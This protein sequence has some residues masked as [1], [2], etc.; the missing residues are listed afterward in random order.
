MINNGPASSTVDP[1]GD[2]TGTWLVQIFNNDNI[3]I[4]QDFSIWQKEETFTNPA[5][6][7]YT[8]DGYVIVSN[9]GGGALPTINVKKNTTD[10]ETGFEQCMELEITN[11]GSAGATRSWA[12]CQRVEDYKKYR[13]KTVTNSFR[14]K[15]SEAITLSGG[16]LQVY[17]GVD[18]AYDVVTS[19]TTDWTTYSATL[20]VAANA[21]QLV[22]HFYLI[23]GTT[24]TISTT[25]S[26][27]IQWMK[28]E[29]SP[30][31]TGPPIPRSEGEELALCQRR[32]QKSYAI[33]EYPGD[34]TSSG[35][36]QVSLLPHSNADY[37]MILTE[38]L[39]T[40]MAGIPTVTIYDMLG[41]PGKVK[42]AA[43]NNITGTVADIT[44]SNFRVEATNGAV[45]TSRE[46]RFHFFAEYD[47]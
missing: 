8:A 39:I 35:P 33:G 19:I 36:T 13:G 5:N 29:L 32:R 25:G 45:S 4:N 11:V 37:S 18:V 16:R 41:N 12:Y 44:D 6:G 7:D 24:G 22:S 14:I 28:L 20:S 42:M 31:F 21:S 3:L 30:G 43:G 34:A 27:Y 46:L 40:R 38:R 10:M 26:I 15:S 17:D 1:V 47:L 2:S 9:A 23:P